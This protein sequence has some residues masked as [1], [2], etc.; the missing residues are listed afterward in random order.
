[1]SFKTAFEY[2]GLCLNPTDIWFLS[3]SNPSK[4]DLLGLRFGI[5]NLM[6]GHAPTFVDAMRALLVGE[7]GEE[8]VAQEVHHI[9]VTPLPPEAEKQGYVKIEKLT[10]FLEWRKTHNCEAE[11]ATKH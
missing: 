5:P 10:T 11:H 9:E 2:R 1:M 6:P 7:L 8:T 3:L 4:P